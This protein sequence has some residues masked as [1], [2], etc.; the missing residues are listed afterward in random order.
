MCPSNVQHDV[1][2][3]KMALLTKTKKLTNNEEIIN[4]F[5]EHITKMSYFVLL[6]ILILFS[7]GNDS[8]K[9]ICSEVKGETTDQS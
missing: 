8:H 7:T 9:C 1:I 4:E 2:E 6:T 5:N 3:V